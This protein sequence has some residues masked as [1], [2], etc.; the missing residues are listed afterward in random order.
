MKFSAT[1]TLATA[2]SLA[3]AQAGHR[4][5]HHH[6]H[7][8]DVATA[9][10]VVDEVVTVYQLD[11]TPV[12]VAEVCK[13][14]KNGEYKWAAGQGPSNAC[15]STTSATVKPHEFL[16]TPT[17]TAVPTTTS[18][19]P[20]STAVPTTSSTTTSTSSTSTSTS[21]TSTSTSTSAPAPSSTAASTSSYSGGTGLTASFPDG[22]LSCDTFPS[23]YGAIALDYF[24]IGGWSGIQYPTLNSLGT[25]VESIVTAVSGQS[26]TEGAMC[27][28]HCPPGYLKSQWPK[29][30][31]ATGQSVGGLT[32]KGG[33]LH[34][35]R[36]DQDTLCIPGVQAVTVENQLRG[37]VSVCR[38]DYPGTESETLPLEVASG[39]VEQLANPDQSTYF[40]W[41]GKRTTAQYY[42]NPEGYGAQDACTWG[43]AGRDLGNFSP[44]NMGIGYSDGTTYLSI[45]PNAPT[46]DAKLKFNVK[47]EGD[48]NPP[49][50][51]DSGSATYYKD[52]VPNQNEGCTVGIPDGGSAKVIFY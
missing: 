36:T 49:C 25:L 19:T 51:Y 50:Y 23:D 31:G 52:G 28:Y 7:K 24:N 4:R 37:V 8:R 47:F 41:Q 5:V 46:T 43:T 3:A 21:T 40:Y 17:S 35:T 48:V 6:Q 13:G 34:R 26:C 2:G 12:P 33:K 22:E 10:T 30:Q 14:I 29:T 16:E 18:T 20:T 42:I 15:Q 44:M 39:S 9:T 27:S 38:T 11:G 32:C 45:F 1:L